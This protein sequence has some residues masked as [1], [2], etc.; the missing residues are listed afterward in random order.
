[1]SKEK[2]PPDVGIRLKDARKNKG[3]TLDAAAKEL[4]IT[5]QTLIKYESGDTS[6]IFQLIEKI[7]LLY[8]VSPNYLFFGSDERLSSLTT[9][10]QRKTYFL[11][12][13]IYDGDLKYDLQEGTI[14]FCDEEMRQSIAYCYAA[15][16]GS[17][18]ESK[19]AVLERILEYLQKGV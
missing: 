10:S 19:L 16:R 18:N 1:M 13:L 4:G 8:D 14:S 11:F 3:L 9:L 2:N 15:L 7:C 6:F 5:K 12:S 17:V